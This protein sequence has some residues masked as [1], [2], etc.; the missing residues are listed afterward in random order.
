MYEDHEIAQYYDPSLLSNYGRRYMLF[1]GV[2]LTLA[3]T[4]ILVPLIIRF[5]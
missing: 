1:A 3:L 2:I 5:A 4:A